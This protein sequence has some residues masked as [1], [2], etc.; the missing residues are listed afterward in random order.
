MRL[1]HYQYQVIYAKADI[2]IEREGRPKTALK[3]GCQHVFF[4]DSVERRNL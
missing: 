1:P 4:R 2:M 3:S